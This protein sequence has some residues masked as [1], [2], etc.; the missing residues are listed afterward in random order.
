M[1][2]CRSWLLLVF[3]LLLPLVSPASSILVTDANE[4]SDA[5][6]HARGGD[7][8][9]LKDGNWQDTQI[10]IDHGGEAGNP[11]EIRAETPGKVILGGS[12]LLVLNAPYVTVDGLFFCK[13][14][15]KTSPVKAGSVKSW[16][17]IWFNSNHDIVRNTAVVD[18]N[19]DSFSTRYYWAGFNGDDN[20]VDHCYFKGKNHTEPVI[21]NN[22]GARHNSVTFSYFKDIP[23]AEPN[24]R[25]I[26]RVWGYGRNG[27][28][29]DDGAF[30]NVESN[31]F[32]HADG[33]GMEIVSLKGNR[34]TVRNNTVLASRGCL[35]IRQGSFNTIEG[36][37]ILCQDVP[38]AYGIR[39]SG[40]N[41]VVR[42]NFISHGERGL[43]I[44]CG[45][46]AGKDLT[47]QYEPSSGG[48]GE[49]AGA[50]KY[51]PVKNLTLLD[52]VVVDSSLF[53]LAIGDVYKI[54]WPKSQMILVP[55]DCLIASNRLV[56]SKGGT[57]V[58]GAVPETDP[59]LDQFTFQPNRYEGNVLVGG[60]D[61]FAPSVDGFTTVAIPGNW[62]EEKEREPFKP[63]TPADV[64][65]DWA[66][67]ENLFSAF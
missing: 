36:N 50:A 9:R 61:K 5:L 66:G 7:V 1:I 59:P 45:D 24:G 33:E 11:V 29:G 54:H 10:A 42:H 34:N 12:S 53:D 22:F 15:M 60:R 37:I 46:Y 58:I 2:A 35:N 25:E 51:L 28:L 38:K 30:F 63:L 39:V 6:E 55:E 48:A 14:S 32:E 56:H 65:P 20:L 8:I 64:G 17:V 21:G 43:V 62:S 40:A 18:Y 19:P 3:G 41:N 23:F 16:A 44:M 52:N 31:L 67:A 4:L 26:I 13:G 57:S 47:G 49:N 27:E